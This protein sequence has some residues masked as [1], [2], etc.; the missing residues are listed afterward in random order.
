MLNNNLPSSFSDPCYSYSLLNS[1]NRS[2]FYDYSSSGGSYMCDSNLVNNWYRFSGAAGPQM[3]D[4][5]VPK[6]RCG[7]HAPGWLNGN[8]PSVGEG[9]VSRTVCFHWSYSCCYWS[10][11]IDVKNCGGYYVYNLHKPPNCWLRYCGTGQG[12]I[13]VFVLEINRSHMFDA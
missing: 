8:H 1:M 2:Q 9:T 11:K 5:C 10:T 12:G 7:A 6:R 13:F 4:S 3:P